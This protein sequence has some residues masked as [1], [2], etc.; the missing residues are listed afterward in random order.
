MNQSPID[1]PT[2]DVINVAYEPLVPVY[3]NTPAN[4]NLTNNGHTFALSALPGQCLASVTGGNLKH[5]YALDNIHFHWG[6]SEHT[7]DGKR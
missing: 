5:L 2:D 1:I 3:Y 7:V 4:Y 6:G